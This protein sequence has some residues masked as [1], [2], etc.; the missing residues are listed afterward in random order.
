VAGIIPEEVI[1]EIRER[2]DIV[3]VIGQHVQLKRSGTN[4]K[5]LCPFHDEKTPSFNV[6]SQKQFYHCFGCHESGDVFAFLMKIEGRRFS[7]VVEDL[8]ARAGVEIPRARV[9]PAQERAA[10]RQRSERQQGLD[11]NRKVADQYRS[12]LGGEK[13]GPA[14]DYLVKRVI[15]DSM[16]ER[17]WL[18]Y[19]PPTGTTITK[20]LEAEGVSLELAERLGLV[21]RRSSGSGYH[22]RFWNRLIFP[23]ISAGG[24]VL[25]FGGRLLGEGDGPKYLNTPETALY[26]KGEV[27]YGMAA[28]NEAMRKLDTALVVE[29]NIDVIQLHHYGFEHAV[30]PMGTSLTVRQIHLIRRFAH[31]VVALFD[32]DEAGNAAALKSVTTLV[33]GGLEA[34]IAS[35]PAGHDPDSFLREHGKEALAKILDSALPAVDYLIEARLKQM[36]DTLPARARFIEEVAPIVAKLESQLDRDLY[37]QRLAS[38]LRIDA[39]VIKGAVAG[40]RPAPEALRAKSRGQKRATLPTDQLYLLG[41]L[42]EYPH[43]LARAEAAGGS[44]LLTNDALRATYHAAMELQQTTGRIEPVQL[45]KGTPD[46]VRNDVAKLIQTREFA[47][48]GD[49]TRALDDCILALQ[50]GEMKRELQEIRTQS[51]KARAAKDTEAERELALRKVALALERKKHETR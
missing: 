24:E 1:A 48:M 12:L 37:T 22:D 29:G 44:S 5:G 33:E 31:K 26:R 36:E 34:K 16:S 27:L 10:A 32:G 9:S 20:L 4:Y 14:R 39:G 21:A 13:G 11:L 17:F 18:G 40:R 2:T 25:G 6:N 8:A 28:A 7:E 45:L 43:L 38:F 47:S 15:S 3:Q 23:V 30:A 49:P 42:F 19:A 51:D 46:E 35:L 50:R 41:V